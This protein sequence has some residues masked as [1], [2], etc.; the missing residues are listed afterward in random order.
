VCPHSSIFPSATVYVKDI[1][2]CH[3]VTDKDASLFGM[4]RH[5][6]W[7]LFTDVSEEHVAFFLSVS[8]RKVS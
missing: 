3:S 6:T 2:G 5:V 4:L 8:L 7:L 1:S